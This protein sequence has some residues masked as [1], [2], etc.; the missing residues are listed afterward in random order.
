MLSLRGSTI[1]NDVDEVVVGSC[2]LRQILAVQLQIFLVFLQ[3][4]IGRGVLFTLKSV[5]MA[6]RLLDAAM[7]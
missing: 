4:C 7:L 6:L 3:F 2:L 5:G 1:D